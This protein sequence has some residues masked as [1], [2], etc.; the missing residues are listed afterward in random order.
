MLFSNQ[1]IIF[2]GLIGNYEQAIYSFWVN[3]AFAARRKFIPVLGKK[4]KMLVVII[5]I[6][7]IL[8]RLIYW[9]SVLKI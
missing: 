6:I 3:F 4:S 7:V 8:C 9:K 2:I 1:D 5:Y